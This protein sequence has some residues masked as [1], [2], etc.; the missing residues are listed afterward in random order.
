[1]EVDKFTFEILSLR[2]LSNIKMAYGFIVQETSD[3]DRQICERLE[4]TVEYG[5]QEMCIINNSGK[6]QY[7]R[8]KREEMPLKETKNGPKRAEKN[9]EGKGSQMPREKRPW[10]MGQI[11]LLSKC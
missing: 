3:L 2:C 1:M 10:S 11:L 6:Y 8:E 5:E 7:L 9:Q 4:V